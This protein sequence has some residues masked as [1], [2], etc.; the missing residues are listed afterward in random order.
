MSDYSVQDTDKELILSSPD[1]ESGVEEPLN[2]QLSFL[3]GDFAV[4]KVYGKTK[5]HFRLYVC[6]VKDYEEGGYICQFYKNNLLR[7]NLL[8]QMKTPSSKVENC[9]Y[10]PDL[11]YC[12]CVLE[13]TRFTEEKHEASL[14]F[15]RE[16]G[17]PQLKQHL[18]PRTK[19]FTCSVPHLRGK[20]DAIYDVQLAFKE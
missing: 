6:Q 7:E 12:I 13:G 9:C 14:A 17:L 18:T 10:S 19:G 11:R 1:E 5:A 4:V 16:K 20:V 3:P 8:L 2:T 15:A